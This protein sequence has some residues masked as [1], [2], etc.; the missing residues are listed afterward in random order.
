MPG[1]VAA[2]VPHTI[3]P[4]DFL[5]PLEKPLH[6]RADEPLE[7]VELVPETIAHCNR[8]GGGSD[9]HDD[10]G[11]NKREDAL[12]PRV[13]PP[14]EGPPVP[15]PS[16]RHKDRVVQEIV[17]QRALRI[18]RKARGAAERRHRDEAKE[19]VR[20]RGGPEVVQ[21]ALPVVGPPVELR[22]D[23]GDVLVEVAGVEEDDGEHAEEVGSAG[24]LHARQLEPPHVLLVHAQPHHEEGQVP[25]G[26]R[27]KVLIEIHVGGEVRGNKGNQYRATEALEVW[28]RQPP[29]EQR[30]HVPRHVVHVI[31]SVFNP[32]VRNT[33]WEGYLECAAEVEEGLEG[34]VSR[35]G[36]AV[37]VPVGLVHPVVSVQ[38][39]REEGEGEPYK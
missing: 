35:C 19:G 3:L 16:C 20:H 25:E 34:Q 22:R 7:E 30:E 6:S 24:V 17:V 37:M 28:H 4:R 5:G 14:Q 23:L 36:L 13:A 31:L 29:E 9:H 33:V 8:D 27:R 18:L 2:T 26:A 12:D 39:E 21:A 32:E 10:K 15:H 1:T 38:H 11:K